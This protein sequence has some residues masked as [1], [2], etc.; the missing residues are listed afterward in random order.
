MPHRIPT[1]FKNKKRVQEQHNFNYPNLLEQ[2]ALPKQLSSPNPRQ[3]GFSYKNPY[4]EPNNGMYY[5]KEKK[6]SS[7]NLLSKVRKTN[8]N[9]NKTNQ[10]FHLNMFQRAMTL[11]NKISDRVFEKHDANGSG[12]LDIREIYPAVCEVFRMNKR[13]LPTY[14]RVLFIMRTFDDDGNGLIDKLEFRNLM[15]NLSC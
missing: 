6:K 8:E 7:Q 10:R 2:H 13:A 12:C 3:T 14:K 15:L 9:K 11:V 4:L 1:N 5:A